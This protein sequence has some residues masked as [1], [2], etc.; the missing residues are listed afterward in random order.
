MGPFVHF[1]HTALRIRF[2]VG[3]EEYSEAERLPGRTGCN[4]NSNCLIGLALD[5]KVG[6]CA[7]VGLEF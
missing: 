4:S 7:L 6:I 5:R 1:T 2:A 3:R